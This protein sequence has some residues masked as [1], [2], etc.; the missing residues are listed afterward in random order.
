MGWERIFPP[1]STPTSHAGGAAKRRARR[2]LGEKECQKKKTALN[3][4]YN[5]S[6][7]FLFKN[8]ANFILNN[9]S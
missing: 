2:A 5:F 9:F 7:G 3:F 1:K 6:K 4:K 8:K